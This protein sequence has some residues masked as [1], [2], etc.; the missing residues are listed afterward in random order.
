MIPFS[1]PPHDYMVS[2][3]QQSQPMRLLREPQPLCAPV[4]M[5]FW[6]Q[7]SR[8]PGTSA[9]QGSPAQQKLCSV[10]STADPLEM[11]HRAGRAPLW[12][13]LSQSHSLHPQQPGRKVELSINVSG[14]LS[15]TLTPLTS[16]N[17]GQS[18]RHSSN[19]R[20]RSTLVA[21]QYMNNYNRKPRSD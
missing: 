10:L 2:P 13:L 12:D 20:L 7:G 8:S 1:N 21:A 19:F 5:D 4:P 16:T 18:T 14:C 3:S 6:Q 9:Q 17:H 15:H 11:L